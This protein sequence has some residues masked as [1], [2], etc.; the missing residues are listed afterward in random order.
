MNDATRTLSW[1]GLLPHE[2]E[3]VRLVQQALPDQLHHDW[4]L[5]DIADADVVLV[6]ADTDAGQRVLADAGPQQRIAALLD[7]NDAM[8]ARASVRLPRPLRPGAVIEVL[9]AADLHGPE[10]EEGEDSAT[11]Y[12]VQPLA[13]A[14]R[15]AVCKHAPGKVRLIEGLAPRPIVVDA[16]HG[17]LRGDAGV[18]DAAQLADETPLPVRIVA[19]EAAEGMTAGATETPLQAHLWRVVCATEDP[20]ALFGDPDHTTVRLTRWPNLVA[21]GVPRDLFRAAT[22]ARTRVVTAQRIASETGLSRA[23]VIALFNAS[24]LTGYLEAAVPEA[25][26]DTT[27]AQ[28]TGARSSLLRRIRNRLGTT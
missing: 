23:R 10:T 21:L 15:E 7:R 19:R 20:R 25:D 18:I 12:C 6:A 17:I 2:I 1:A 16:A 8:P 3:T 26:T 24:W 9:N 13:P 27:P 4:R 5:G 22:H 11:P 28:L 14:L